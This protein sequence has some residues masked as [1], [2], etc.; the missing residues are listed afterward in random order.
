MKDLPI[1]QVSKSQGR[2]LQMPIQPDAKIVQ[3]DFSGQTSLKSGKGIWTTKSIEEFVKDTLTT[4]Q[5]MCC[6]NP[7]WERVGINLKIERK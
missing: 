3:T 2:P 5:A 6:F 4:L 7:D 1:K